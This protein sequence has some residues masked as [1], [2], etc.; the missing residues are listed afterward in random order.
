MRA[1]S[2]GSYRCQARSVN[3]T[4]PKLG[5]FSIIVLPLHVMSHVV[6]KFHVL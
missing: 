3:E 4:I 2:P 5:L 1:T 6:E